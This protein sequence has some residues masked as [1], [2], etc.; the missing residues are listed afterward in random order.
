MNFTCNFENLHGFLSLRHHVF[1]LRLWEN[2]TGVGRMGG[3]TLDIVRAGG[4]TYSLGKRGRKKSH[5]GWAQV[6]AWFCKAVRM[7]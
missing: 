6:S 1:F 5:E 7:L 4:P 3:A 2:D